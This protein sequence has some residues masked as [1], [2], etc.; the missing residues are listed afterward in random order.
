LPPQ[1]EGNPIPHLWLRK[2]SRR[3]RVLWIGG[4]LIASRIG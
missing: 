3:G 4:Y 1:A 2:G